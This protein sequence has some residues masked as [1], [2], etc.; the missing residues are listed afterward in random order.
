MENLVEEKP[1]KFPCREVLCIATSKEEILYWAA[2]CTG[3]ELQNRSFCRYYEIIHNDNHI[4]VVLENIG[5]GVSVEN[6]YIFG[7]TK[8]MKQ[9]R[10]VLYRL[11]NTEVKVQQKNGKL[12]I[13][14]ASNGDVILEQSLE[15][16]WPV[17][18]GNIIK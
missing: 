5:S 17:W 4:I 7:K 11:T 8:E 13:T 14:N 9:W 1:K 6:F 18:E 2:Q 16:L 10:L 15:V 3:W 12:I